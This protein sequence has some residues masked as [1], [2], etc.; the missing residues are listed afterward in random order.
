MDD[1]TIN[2]ISVIRGRENE[3]TNIACSLQARIPHSVSVHAFGKD[4]E[5]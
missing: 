5:G 3:H 1:L 2:K 4:A